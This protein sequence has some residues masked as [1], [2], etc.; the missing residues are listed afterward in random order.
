MF[1]SKRKMPELISPAGDW[2]SVQ[3]AIA[4]GADSVYFGVK[5]LNMRNS[6]SNFDMLEMKKLMDMLHLAGKK[7]Y[8]T[9]N[10]VLYNRDIDKAKKILDE[11]VSAGVDAVVL[12]DM[13]AM[14]L[15]RERGISVH[16]S[17][18]AGISNFTALKEYASMGA[19]KVVLARECGLEDIREIVSR[20]EEEGINCGIETFIHGAMCV[21]ISGRCFLSQ[22]TFS[23][24]ANR[25]ECLQPC[26]REFL[27]VDEDKECEYILGKDYILSPKDL[28]TI[29][30]I[31]EL[32]EAGIH[33]F[34]IEGRMR[35]PEYVKAVT[36]AYRKAIDMYSEGKLTSG[37]KEELLVGLAATFNRGFSEGFY[38]GV[39][40][41]TGGVAAGDYEK[42]YVGEVIKFYKKIKV[43]EIL[44]N[45]RGLR[46]GQ[47]ILISG[48]STGAQFAVINQMEIDHKSVDEVKKGERVGIN[49]PFDVRARDKVFLWISK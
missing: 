16:I 47:K 33:A 22:H 42:I 35:S 25:G 9:L 21:S 43:A 40:D 19:E 14:S 13:A 26:R 4:A 7:G 39:P 6:A 36:S 44:V 20:I 8:L 31:D 30:F 41:D 46:K 49:L 12:W 34:K 3:S 38:H 1:I 37:V 17:T 48:K 27:I 2:S 15:A 10:V 45:T 23:K 32:I 29:G 11:A 18:Q 5:G 24:S 28:C